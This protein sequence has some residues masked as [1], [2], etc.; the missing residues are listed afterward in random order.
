[1]PV[2]IGVL[3]RLSS[4]YD[5]VPIFLCSRGDWGCSARNGRVRIKLD[6]ENG[7]VSVGFLS[8]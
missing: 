7:I 8:P 2:G 4:V 6:N 1:V 5:I 3:V